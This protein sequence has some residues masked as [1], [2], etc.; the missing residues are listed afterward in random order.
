MPP[1]PPCLSSPFLLSIAPLKL[2]RRFPCP[3]PSHPPPL[4]F[5]S[6]CFTSPPF[7][8][9]LPP[10]PSVF[11]S[12]PPFPRLP[13]PPLL[14]SAALGLS[15]LPRSVRGA[16][17]LFWRPEPVTRHRRNRGAKRRNGKKRKRH[18]ERP[19]QRKREDTRYTSSLLYRRGALPKLNTATGE[20][21]SVKARR[22]DP[23]VG[24]KDDATVSFPFDT[25]I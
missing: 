19:F 5:A 14:V 20:I 16:L 6:E 10:F 4:A 13:S 21:V 7:S 15:P 1:F 24:R 3:C 2:S 17:A 22:G 12:L 18:T 23:V 8:L 11:N 9:L 25:E